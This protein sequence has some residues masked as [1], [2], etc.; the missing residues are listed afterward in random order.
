MVFASGKL[1]LIFGAVGHRPEQVSKTG[2]GPTV[3]N[4]LTVRSPDRKL[5]ALPRGEA[6]QRGPS[7]IVH[8]DA[9]S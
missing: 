5:A 4:A 3:G 9:P 2:S 8:P 7:K 1:F 6:C